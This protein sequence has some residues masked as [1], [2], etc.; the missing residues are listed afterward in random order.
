MRTETERL[1]SYRASFLEKVKKWKWDEPEECV[2]KRRGRKPK[3]SE[4]IESKPR[5]AGERKAALKQSKYNWL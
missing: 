3:S 4:R 5:T 2:Y 1:A